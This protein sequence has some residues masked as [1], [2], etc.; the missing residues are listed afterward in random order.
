MKPIKYRPQ[1]FSGD[2]VKILQ[3][4]YQ[5]EVAVVISTSITQVQVLM[6]SGATMIFDRNSVE[7]I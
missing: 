7:K 3:G 4:R 2:K 6:L 5:N 1:F